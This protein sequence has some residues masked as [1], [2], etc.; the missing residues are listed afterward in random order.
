MFGGV[1]WNRRPHRPVA[2][3]LSQALP[4]GEMGRALRYGLQSSQRI[5]LPLSLTIL[6]P[7]ANRMRYRATRYVVTWG[8]E[9]STAR[10]EAEEEIRDERR[11]LEILNRAGSALALETDLQKVVQIATDAGVELT[12]GQ[13]GTFFYNVVDESGESRLLYLLSGAPS[14]VSKFQ[15]PRNTVVFGRLFEG[16]G[17][18]RSDD[19]TKEQL[20]Q[21]CAVQ[22]HTEGPPAGA[23]P[24]GRARDVQKRRHRRAPFLC[25]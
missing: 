20:R 13:F 17:L 9:I 10:R 3:I 18:V 1:N 24:S 21:Q 7:K 2:T 4:Q 15:M 19:S 12:G 11:T 5:S 25:P 14:A 22:R 6:Y 8:T 23:K 16:K